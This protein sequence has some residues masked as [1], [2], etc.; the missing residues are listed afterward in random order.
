MAKVYLSRRAQFAASH[1]MYRPEWSDAENARAFGKCSHPNG[2]GHNYE[3]EVILAGEV[4]PKTDMV[5]N[6]TEVKDILE[7]HVLRHVD[8][9]N[10]N[11]DVPQLEG[12]VPTAENIAVAIWGMLAPHL[13]KGCLQEV[14][15]RETE[16]NLAVYKGE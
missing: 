9:R 6:L 12:V 3:L 10:L 16:N 11:V 5:I 4:N 8:H 14:R 7:E 13:P 2:H 15:L 1:R